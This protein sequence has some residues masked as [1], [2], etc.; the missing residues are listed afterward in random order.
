MRGII[1]IAMLK[2][3]KKSQ[4]EFVTHEDE[5]IHRYERL[6]GAAR[7]LTSYD[8]H[9]AE[10][11][12]HEAF[13][14]FTLARPALEEIENL[15]GYFYGMLRKLYISHQ[16]RATRLQYFSSS[17]VEYDTLE[18][19]LRVMDVNVHL[20]IHEEL[21]MICHY[22]CTR[23][24]SSKAG[25][26]LILRFFHG[27]YP[28]EIAQLI[29]SPRS[30]VDDWLRIARREV[31]IY[32]N[33]PGS[34]SFMTRNPETKLPEISPGQTPFELL[35]RLRKN[36]FASRHPVGF[37]QT[38]IQELYTPNKNN[39]LDSSTLAQLV[40]CPQCLD[41]VNLL[42]GIPPL[43]ER[44]PTDMLGPEKPPDK[45]GD[46]GSGGGAGTG[47]MDQLEIM[48]RRRRRGTF[49]HRPTELHF[50]VNGYV[51]S[52]L[53]VNADRNEQSQR[54]SLDEKIS[55]VEVFSEQGERL[56]LLDV[57]QPPE[58]AIMQQTRAILSDERRLELSLDF[59][60][61]WPVLHS[62]YLDPLMKT[63]VAG[64][65]LAQDDETAMQTA[66]AMESRQ[67]FEFLKELRR[68]FKLR[69]LSSAFW[70]RPATITAFVSALLIV[71]LLL[72]R[73]PRGT[74]SAAELLRDS[75]AAEDAIAAHTDQALHR[76]IALEERNPADGSLIERR[77]IEIWHS[78]ERRETSRRLFDD[79]NR[80]VAGEWVK[81]GD[82]PLRWQHGGKLETISAPNAPL[83][84]DESVWLLTPSAKEFSALIG[85]AENARVEEQSLV[86]RISYESE[87]PADKDSLVKASLVI[88]K[89][90]LRAIEQSLLIKTGTS[91]P[92]LR[93]YRFTET[94]FERH[95][96][97]T[98]APAVFEPD[99][100]LLVSGKASANIRNEAADST[101]LTSSTPA[102]AA[103]AELEV[104]V[105]DLMNRA[106]ALTGEQ[107]SLIRTPEGRLVVRGLV[108]TIA[109]KSELL[110]ALDSVARNPAVVIEIQ[111]IAEA[112][113]KMKA[114]SA[115]PGTILEA[116]ITERE[117][118]VATE[119]RL[120]LSDS[121][122]MSGEQAEAEIRRI[123]NSVLSQSTQA[124]QNALAIKQ[125]AERFSAT[126]L[127]SMDVAA[128]QRWQAMIRDRAQALRRALGQ[129]R[130]ELAPIFPAASAGANADR[131]GINDGNLPDA[132]R[133]LFNLV[134][135]TDSGIKTS[136]SL[137]TLQSDETAVKTTQFW[138][139]LGKAEAL[140]ASLAERQ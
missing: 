82:S 15:D 130:R 58:G 121:K 111:T 118:P 108:E 93:E 100:A 127:E 99:P 19:G 10:D 60:G 105:L 120:Y 66:P 80:L 75:A 135:A 26:V 9:L 132:V 73:M 47:N 70:L 8:E 137:S 28:S 52:S 126:E 123:S 106:N 69:W 59:S 129:L 87:A 48:M 22:A 41:R 46:S 24:D 112:Q 37:P 94:S 34:L 54:I 43:A 36:V 17:L 110:R 33:D 2:F 78:A 128:R 79:K 38:Q 109:R 50:A 23:K 40:S 35:I 76:T 117:I 49:E 21:R 77:R 32:L 124:R 45:P 101:T 138:L 44:F 16:R 27:Y 56:L 57:A 97:D 11:L 12:V 95:A 92:T 62:V 39:A 81:P 84:T 85:N 5:F 4:A 1:E 61:S 14:Q 140:A 67:S 131:P 83:L 7:K 134:I 63:A 89:D 114:S 18:S 133:R 51:L 96:A 115:K 102:V 98:I 31:K 3:L 65:D 20:R 42:L 122:G 29:G 119:L 6:I 72:A 86:Y 64:K 91:D 88:N 55:F 30:A 90:D 13:V 136:F 104:E 25:S 116:E 113:A 125:I 71:A 103:S 53:S 139:N 107:L 74:V 68:R